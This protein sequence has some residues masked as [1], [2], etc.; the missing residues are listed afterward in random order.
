MIQTDPENKFSPLPNYLENHREGIVNFGLY[1][2]KF[3]KYHR[4]GDFS[5]E[6]RHSWD[7]GKKEW[8]LIN[9]QFDQYHKYLSSNILK[10]RHLQQERYL[11]ALSEHGVKTLTLS[12]RSETRFLTGI[13]ETS[14]TEVGMLFDR[15]SGV[16]YIPASSVKG[17]VRYAYCV[18]FARKNPE[19]IADGKFVDEKDIDG[20][21][22]LFGSL[23]SKNSSRGGYAFMDVYA[24]EAPEIIIDIMNPHFGKYYKGDSTEG[25][26]ETE[27]P[28]PIKFLAIEKG[29]V[30]KFRGFFLSTEAE[31]YCEQLVEAFVT[32]LTELGI[33]AK[34]ALGY[35]RFDHAQE[36][37]FQKLANGKP[38]VK[39][40]TDE[41][42]LMKNFN[43]FRLSPSPDNF[44]RFVK[45]IRLE[46]MEEVKDL[47]FKE[48]KGLINIGFADR[49]I[50]S[51][52]NEDLK[53]IIAGKIFNLLEKNKKWKQKKLESYRSLEILANKNRR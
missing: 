13:G 40:T 53:I 5:L 37:E 43:D 6:T 52:I 46:E 39:K 28:V 17:V 16:P 50:D 11:S 1:F 10:K 27:D 23:D 45:R 33:G 3:A 19:K 20:L 34:T 32:A 4:K 26:V 31:S 48:M 38:G 41:S 25:P 18:N 42:D 44:G 22:P 21:I 12:F 7:K 24:E 29:V 8:S 9:N 2:Q 35:G 49:L 47:S 51:E 30:F 14:P 36:K 15:N